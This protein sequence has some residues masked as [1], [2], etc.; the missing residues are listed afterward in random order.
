ML[1]VIA[2]QVGRNDK[3]VDLITKALAIKPDL[4]EAHN[5]LGNA[6]RELSKLKEAVPLELVYYLP[7][8]GVDCLD[9]FSVGLGPST[10]L[11][12]RCNNPRPSFRRPRSGTPAAVKLAPVPNSNCRFLAEST[13]T[14]FS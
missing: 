7:Q 9:F 13:A 1:G 3:A 5:N 12:V 6:L 4:A 14:I 2:H 8:L 10:V 11:R